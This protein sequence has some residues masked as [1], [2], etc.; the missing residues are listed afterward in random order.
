MEALTSALPGSKLPLVH[1]RYND[2]CR[3]RAPPVGQGDA[4][5]ERGSAVGRV[6]ID[7]VHRRT[8]AIACNA[9]KAVDAA[10]IGDSDNIH[11]NNRAPY[12]T[13]R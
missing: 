5:A 2:W 11:Q 13:H 9:T 8:R 7:P 1:R 10:Y 3:F 6:G 12:L 4:A